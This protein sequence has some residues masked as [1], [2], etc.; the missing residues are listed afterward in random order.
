MASRDYYNVLGIHRDA[1]ADAIKRAYRRAAMRWHP[2]R[3]QGDP[4]AEQRFKDVHEAY[5][6]LSDPA[7]RARYDRLG[8]MY[9]PD[10][11]PPTPDELRAALRN[12]WNN[13]WGRQSNAPGED[14]KYT[15]SVQLEEVAD[16]VT[17]ELVVP[18]KLRCGDC[19]GHGAQP[20]DRTTCPVCDGSGRSKG[21]RLLRTPCY[22]CDGRGW[23][24]E[25]A[26][27]TCHGE[28][29][30]EQED[31][32]KVKVPPGVS[33]G[34]KLKLSGKGN[35]AAGDGTTGDLYVVVHV[36]EH[37][38]FRRRGDD[39]IVDLPLRYD[40]AVLGADVTV[41]T[42]HGTTTIRIPPG[43]VPGQ[44]FRLSGRGLPGVGRGSRGDLHARVVLD[45]PTDLTAP[46]HE[47]LRRWA[48]ALPPGRHT[49]RAAFHAA[50]EDRR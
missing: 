18:R 29:R 14:L 9:T 43:T 23:V 42:L 8:P 1:D 20:A 32:L 3:N 44:Q 35:E 13:L 48:D 50:L 5:K 45:I 38:L 28:G 31:P 34:Q 17:K 49:R 7:Q 39:V 40:E 30:V 21:P 24:P 41:P 2:D 22:H 26:C 12:A 10:G 37:D 36:V 19:G 15:I 25:R 6:V 4:V 27:P 47:A 46:E 11:K 33:T 16:G